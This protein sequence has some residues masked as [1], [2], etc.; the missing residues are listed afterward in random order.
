MSE[1]DE[2]RIRPPAGPCFTMTAD[3]FR[4][5]NRA[6]YIAPVQKDRRPAI[7]PGS[8]T[9]VSWGDALPRVV[10]PVAETAH[11]LGFYD[12]GCADQEALAL[13]PRC[14]KRIDELTIDDYARGV[15]R[16]FDTYRLF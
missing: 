12:F 1:S 8:I 11:A 7:L 4:R 14:D 10:D 15:R 2:A 16:M 6:Q 5:F 13:E 3:E 9:Y